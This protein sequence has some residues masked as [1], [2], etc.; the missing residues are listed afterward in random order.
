MHQHTGVREQAQ[1]LH[2]WQALHPLAVTQPLGFYPSGIFTTA[3]WIPAKVIAMSLVG[4]PSDFGIHTCRL[5]ICNNVS[6]QTHAAHLFI[7]LFI[8]FHYL[9]DFIEDSFY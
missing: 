5:T 3:G 8:R 1:A 2:V 4:I 7:Y 6:L 9:L